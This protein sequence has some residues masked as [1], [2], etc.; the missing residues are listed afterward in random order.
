MVKKIFR[1]ID[2]FDFTSFFGVDFFKFS[3]PL[4]LWENQMVSNV[5][6]LGLDVV[7]SNRGTKIPDPFFHTWNGLPK[8]ESGR[9]NFVYWN[10]VGLW[11][12]EKLM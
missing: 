2:L 3:G 11:F 8:D 6:G 5:T 9:A 12:D 10:L 1:E 4:C 7:G